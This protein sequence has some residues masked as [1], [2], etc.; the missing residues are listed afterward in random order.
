[1]S[2]CAGLVLPGLVGVSNATGL[3][4]RKKNDTVLHYFMVFLIDQF[5]TL[6]L[7][8]SQ[9]METRHLLKPALHP[10]LSEFVTI[11]MVD[12]SFV[13]FNKNVLTNKNGNS[14]YFVFVTG[15]LQSRVNEINNRLL[16]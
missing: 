9:K 4:T 13:H 7:I 5:S 16:K 8:I 12:F 1:M 2:C 14:N 6:N 3:D 10:T 15:G 11:K